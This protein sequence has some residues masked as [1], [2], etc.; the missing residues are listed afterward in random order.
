[1]NFERFQRKFVNAV[2]RFGLRPLVRIKINEL[3]HVPQQGPLLIYPNHIIAFEVPLIYH[4]LQPRLV[5]AM[6]K[7]ESWD[8]RFYA[9]LFDLW[10]IV[11]VKRGQADTTAI[12]HSLQML[13]EGYVFTISPEG[14]RSHDGKLIKA[15]PGIVPIALKSGAPLMPI[16]HWG[17]EKLPQN[18]KKLR[19]TNF[20]IRTGKA[21]YLD[22]RGERVTKEVRQEMVDEMMILLARLLPEEYR[23]YYTDKIGKEL[24]YIRYQ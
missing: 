16:A 11:P 19:R 13:D 24:K 18:L 9:W 23:G 21:F 5:S 17:I 22:P 15:H 6:A 4:L 3:D 20:H 7:A 2:L 8:N 12:R 10:K 1:M 14:T